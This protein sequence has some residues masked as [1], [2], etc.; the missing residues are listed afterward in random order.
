[1]V[2]PSST[3]SPR[4]FMAVVQL[5]SPP[6]TKGVLISQLFLNEKTVRASAVAIIL[7]ILATLFNPIPSQLVEGFSLVEVDNIPVIIEA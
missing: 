2:F 7:I 1:M 4:T 5:F 3:P 6:L